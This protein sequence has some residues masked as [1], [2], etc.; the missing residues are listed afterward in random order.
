MPPFPAGQLSRGGGRTDGRALPNGGDFRFCLLDPTGEGRDVQGQGCL[1]QPD[2]HAVE[3]GGQALDRVQPSL[4]RQLPWL[5]RNGRSHS[6]FISQYGWFDW[7]ITVSRH[8]AARLTELLSC[9]PIIHLAKGVHTIVYMLTD[10]KHMDNHTAY[11]VG[12]SRPSGP[13]SQVGCPADRVEVG[14]LIG[15]AGPPPRSIMPHRLTR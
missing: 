5:R 7:S 9:I 14:L 11:G 10:L 6:A 15:E 13:T 12:F 2:H 3:G 1:V 8:V 4:M